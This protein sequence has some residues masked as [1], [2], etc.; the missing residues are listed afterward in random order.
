[1]ITYVVNG[2]RIEMGI[3]IFCFKDV[4]S[5]DEACASSDR[6]LF[7]E[8]FAVVKRFAGERLDCVCYGGYEYRYRTTPR[9]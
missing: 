9:G 5:D 6:W 1:M 3:A 4:A 7:T 8:L 2:V